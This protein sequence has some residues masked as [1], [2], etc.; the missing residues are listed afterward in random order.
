MC[1]DQRAGGGRRGQDHR[2]LQRQQD[3]VSALLL[4]LL[5]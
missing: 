2:E 3:A 1:R 5:S 4:L